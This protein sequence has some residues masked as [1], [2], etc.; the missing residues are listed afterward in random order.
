MGGDS[1]STELWELSRILKSVGERRGNKSLFKL[2][3][4]ILQMLVY[5][6]G[7]QP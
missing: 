7:A 2:R 6:C 5:Y 4:S 1:L 3:G